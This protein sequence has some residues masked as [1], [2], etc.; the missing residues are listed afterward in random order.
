MLTLA[1]LTKIPKAQD[2][3]VIIMLQNRTGQPLGSGLVLIALEPLDLLFPCGQG[4]EA[5]MSRERRPLKQDNGGPS[6]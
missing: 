2:V 4:Q 3:F 1:C 6:Y 5:N